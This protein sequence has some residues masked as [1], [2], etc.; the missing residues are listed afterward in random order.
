MSILFGIL[1][2]L[3]ILVILQDAFESIVLPR[4]VARRFRFARLFYTT[5]WGLWSMSARKMRSTNR[6]EFF[7]SIFGP[8]SLIVLLVCWG[9]IL[10]VAFALVQ[11]AIGPDIFTP[12]R[13]VNF[14]TYLY[15]S[16]VTF[17]TLGY[18]DV[19]PVTGLART[20]AVVETGTG[21]GF[22]ALVIGYVPVI[23]QA[24]SRRESEITLLDARA[25]SPPSAIELLRRYALHRQDKNV[26]ELLYYLR[27][28]EHWCSDILESHLSYSVLMYYR[29]QHDRESWLAALTAMLDLCALLMVGLDNVPDHAARFTFAM[30]R[31]AAVD[32][33]QV[34]GTPPETLGTS[35][36]SAEDFALLRRNLA[37]FGLNFRD[38][39]TAEAKLA[40]LRGM[41]EPYVSALA[42]HLLMPL[43]EWMPRNQVLDD[44]QTS[45]WD[46]FS[47]TSQRPLNKTR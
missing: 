8:L 15:F 41:Y 2:I 42:D 4:R 39:E 32:L 34:F 14:G 44:W 47:L 36:L 29:S 28:W 37:E 46:H 1:G 21:F 20:L 24:F 31:H 16:G 12:E 23:Y 5:L 22:L 17:F 43:P 9:G 30:A 7:L 27:N 26:E 6:R 45:I 3:S 11:W 40:S 25:G 13:T 35:R 38:G 33:A 10:V 19:V 18:G